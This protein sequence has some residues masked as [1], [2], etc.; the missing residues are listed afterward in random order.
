[1]AY[2]IEALLRPAYELRASCVSAL[3]AGVVLVAPGL[4][5]LSQPWDWLLAGVL[6]G[7]AAWRGAAGLHGHDPHRIQLG[8]VIHDVVAAHCGAPTVV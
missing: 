7:H 8:H 1:M 3:G 2:P 6:M 4:F 5:L